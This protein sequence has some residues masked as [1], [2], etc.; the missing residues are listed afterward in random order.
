MG[1]ALPWYQKKQ[2]QDE[3]EI[4]PGKNPFISGYL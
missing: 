1:D 2:V 4:T 3:D